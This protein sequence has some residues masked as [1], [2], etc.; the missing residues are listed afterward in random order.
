MATATPVS[1]A[2][3]IDW[4]T[5][6]TYRFEPYTDM[7]ALLRRHNPKWSAGRWLQYQGFHTRDGMFYGHT[8]QTNDKEH[9]IVRISGSQAQ[10]IA[11]LILA[12]PDLA[13][14]FYS[15]RLDV[16]RTRYIPDWWDVRRLHDRLKNLGLFVSMIQSETGSTLY[17]GSRKSPRFTRFYVKEF[18]PPMLRLEIELKGAYARLAWN[19]LLDRQLVADLYAANLRRLGLPSN[20]IHDYMPVETSDLDWIAAGKT[21]DAQ[22]QFKWL[23]SLSAKLQAMANDHDIGPMTRDFF[24]SLAQSVDTDSGDVIS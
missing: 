23:M 6:C 10:E 4:L 11:D 17:V 24:W 16:Q 12:N 9:Y 15:T 2:P 14:S 8:Q 18:V 20:I 13:K 21:A 19:L 3:A 5:L 7:V 22:K 1:F